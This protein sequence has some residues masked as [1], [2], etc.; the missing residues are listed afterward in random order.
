[1]FAAAPFHNTPTPPAQYGRQQVSYTPT[2]EAGQVKGRPVSRFGMLT[3][4]QWAYGETWKRENLTPVTNP[5]PAPEPR[6]LR[7][8]PYDVLVSADGTK[9]Y[10]S[11]LGSEANPGHEVIVCDAQTGQVLRRI[12]L[13]LPGSG[14]EPGTGPSRMELHP[15]G[16][17]LVVLN[18]FSNFASVIDTA[19]DVVCAEIPLD[20]YCQDLVFNADGGI[21]YVSNRY[22]EQVLLVDVTVEPGQG[23]AEP[24][25][26]G[27]QRVLGGFDEAAYIAPEGVGPVLQ[28]HCGTIGCHDEY[29]GGFVA[30][31][32]LSASFATALEHLVPGQ[33]EESRLLRAVTRSRDGGYADI[34]PY[35]RSHAGQ[36]VVFPDA[37]ND[38]DYQKLATWVNETRPG[39]GIPVGNPGSKPMAL[40]LGS[41][42]RY[43]YVGNTG[44]QDISII[45]L[46]L[47]CEVGAIY[48]QNAVA[49][50]VVHRAPENG[51]DWLLVATMGVG[52]GVSKERD[53]WGSETWDETAVAAQF[54][55]HRDVDTAEV[56]PKD[57]QEI[58][59]PYD[60]IDGTA[61]I[62]FRD[63]QND[64]V[65][66]DVSALSIPETP[67]TDGLT[68]LLKANRYE[69][70]RGWVRYTSDTAE[71]LYGDVKG[72]IPPDLMRVVGALPLRL[73]KQD[74]RL[75]VCMQGSNQVQ[76]L[77]IEPTASDPSNVLTPTR[78][79]ATGFEPCGL[80]VA[81]TNT[82][83]SGRLFTANFLGGTM[84]LID[85]DV[86]WRQGAG[87]QTEPSTEVVVDP[88]VLQLPVP[89][90]DAE[91]G[92]LL[93]HNSMFS[94]DHDSAC[95]SCHFQE[96]GDGRPWGVSQVVGQEYLSGE[97]R[98]GQLIEGTTM[99]VPQQRG[100]W[101]LQPFFFEGTLSVYDPRSMLMEHCPADDFRGVTPAGDYR[102]IEAH[103]PLHAIA[104][105][106]SKMNSQA[107]SE[108]GIEERRNAFFREAT[109]RTMGK[110]FVL[111]DFQR[112]VGEWQANEPRLMPVPFDQENASVLRG[113][114]LFNEAQTGC[115]SCHPA[116]HFA[117]KDMPNNPRQV[118]PPQ[119][120]MSVRDGSFTL[121]SMERLDALAGIIRDLEPW[122][123]GRS[124]D[125]QVHYTPFGLRGMWDRPPVFLHNGI[126]RT[127]R[128]VVSVPGQTHLRRFKYEPL[129]GGEPE[130]P[131]RREVGFNETY[132]V[133]A[134]NDKNK[135][136][137]D[138]GGRIG[139]DTHGG[140]SHLTATQ[141]DDLVNYLLSIQ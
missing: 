84:S 113:R 115:A 73:V 54:S 12:T 2:D 97:D 99:M 47:G 131:H 66:I 132:F 6:P 101:G 129:M 22:L 120:T 107:T 63:I 36:T 28:A 112:F 3:S 92:E 4:R 117:K 60:A 127:V 32:D 58:L 31:A 130:R 76:E 13:A 62:K 103:E 133:K 59:G 11:L 108:A 128:E 77:R 123:P 83:T 39:P 21:A 68:Y 96:T 10:L 80:A 136:H 124:E 102:A 42:G 26:R 50:L 79:F 100:L 46:K 138:T 35:F 70:H 89:A 52:F 90:T 140:T 106:Q 45:D 64:L 82:P 43:L 85:T 41:E 74:D 61:G 119:V 8:H 98:V 19:R 86:R 125:E 25:F 72:D 139:S 38:A 95:V 69:S 91:R 48:V 141:I 118:V 23:G 55:V 15:D 93:V 88:S 56:L 51:H 20:F 33:A 137:L 75:Y 9:T 65:A 1:M 126:A 135:T 71:S 5:N 105:V 116:P 104:D 14:D 109:L 44:T 30:G 17:F 40:A 34:L 16:R 114:A 87:Y 49:D 81:P 78:V 24:I 27:Q 134:R 111:R 53:P 67:P 121:L 37:T 122:D 7:D 18:R 94:S 29:R 110:S 57:Q